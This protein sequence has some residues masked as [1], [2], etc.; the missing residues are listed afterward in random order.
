MEDA[1]DAKKQFLCVFS[2]AFFAFK[3][4][5]SIQ[6]KSD[7]SEVWLRVVLR[8]SSPGF[9]QKVNHIPFVINLCPRERIAPI[10]ISDL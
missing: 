9:L 3:V 1:K 7:L 2:F 6:I 8:F 5:P 4:F 10:F